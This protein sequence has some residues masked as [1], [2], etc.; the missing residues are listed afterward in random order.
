MYRTYACRV[1]LLVVTQISPVTPPAS[2]MADA[3]TQQ[4]IGGHSRR[5]CTVYTSVLGASTTVRA[6]LPNSVIDRP[7]GSPFC[8]GSIST[9]IF[10][11][12]QY[13]FPTLRLFDSSFYLQYQ[14]VC[15]I[16]SCQQLST[17]K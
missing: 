16:N 9:E 5:T 10:V 14:V 3:A 7:V 1:C 13:V 15:Y 2:W 11:A 17:N 12:H 4:F 6:C 8:S